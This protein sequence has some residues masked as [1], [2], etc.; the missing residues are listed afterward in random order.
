MTVSNLVK[1]VRKDIYRN[2]NIQ[3][4]AMRIINGEDGYYI[5]I[6]YRTLKDEVIDD[7][8]QS[9]D[10]DNL[11]LLKSEFKKYKNGLKKEF[12]MDILDFGLVAI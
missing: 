10:T 9:E 12:N 7:C 8:Y 2:E 6:Q 4:I 1:K 5:D 11:K 3:V